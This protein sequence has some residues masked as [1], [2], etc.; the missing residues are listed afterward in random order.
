VIFQHPLDASRVSL[1]VPGI[2]SVEI[3]D[4][5]ALRFSSRFGAGPWATHSADV[6]PLPD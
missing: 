2:D 6:R 5:D 4:I 3:A 1:R